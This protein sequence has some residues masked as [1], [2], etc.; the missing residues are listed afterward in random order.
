MAATAEVIPFAVPAQAIPAPQ[1]IPQET[2]A[3]VPALT[4][5]QARNHQPGVRTFYVM[6]DSGQEYVVQYVRH[7]HQRRFFCTCPDFTFRRLPKRRHCKHAR[8]VAALVRPRSGIGLRTR[9]GEIRGVPIT[10]LSE[11]RIER[12]R[13]AH[14]EAMANV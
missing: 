4:I 8:R 13:E 14:Y 2:R 7:A 10:E 6:G 1:A 3:R 9:L 5:R 12:M 11:E